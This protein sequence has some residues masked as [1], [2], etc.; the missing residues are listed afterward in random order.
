MVHDILRVGLGGIVGKPA[1]ARNKRQQAIIDA[2]AE[3][4][5]SAV[6]VNVVGSQQFLAIINLPH[7]VIE[8]AFFGSLTFW[9]AKVRKYFDLCQ[10]DGIFLQKTF[11]MLVCV[12]TRQYLCIGF[13]R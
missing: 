3:G 10:Q 5:L 9:R 11:E 1:G 2:V 4:V 13:Q 8:P 12:R 7:T 6:D